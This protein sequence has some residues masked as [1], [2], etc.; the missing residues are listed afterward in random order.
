MKTYIY[1]FKNNETSFSI[2]CKSKSEA[3]VIFKKYFS[4]NAN[5]EKVY[6]SRISIL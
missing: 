5:F 3:K 4:K 1:T 6:L 2:D